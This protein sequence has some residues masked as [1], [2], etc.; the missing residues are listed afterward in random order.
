MMAPTPYTTSEESTRSAE[1]KQQF[2]FL[3][4]VYGPLGKL[5]I[6]TI[7]TKLTSQS[8]K[9]ALNKSLAVLYLQ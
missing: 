6:Q 8:F 9:P 2:T 3:K 7:Q 1:E 5:R 4:I